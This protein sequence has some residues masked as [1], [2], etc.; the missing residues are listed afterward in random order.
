M[1]NFV[2]SSSVLDERNACGYFFS[3]TQTSCVYLLMCDLC[4][5][6]MQAAVSVKALEKHL[7]QKKD[8]DPIMAGILEE[9]RHVFH[10]TLENLVP[11]L[12][13]ELESQVSNFV[14]AN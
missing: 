3:N 8:T 14:S 6:S 5:M 7:Q 10:L 13:G 4:H 9:V 1:A 2:K 11:L 12:I